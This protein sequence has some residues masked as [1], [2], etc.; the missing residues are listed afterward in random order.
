MEKITF[1]KPDDWHVHFRDGVYLSSTVPATAKDCAR[2]L[3]MPNLVPPILSLDDAQAYKKRILDSLPQGHSF[4]PLM[5]LYLTDHISTETLT[6]AKDSGV[7]YGCKLY[8]AGA[9]THSQQGI[10][11][12]EKLY[13]IFSHMEKL[14]LPLLIH[15][16]V[17]D[18][19]VDVFDREKRFI[20]D[21]L[22]AICQHFPE[23]PI[24]LEHITTKD[25]VHF[26]ENAS[27]TVAATITVHHLRHNRNALFQKG[28]NP[29][30]YCL[31]VLKRQEH[32]EALIKAATSGNKKFFL[33]TDSAPHTK[34]TKENACGCA[35]IF[36]APTALPL[37]AEIFE[38]ANALE[39]L[40]AFCSINGASFY[41]VPVN[42]GTITLTKQSWT[43]PE[44]FSF[45]PSVVI[46]LAAGETL[47]WQIIHE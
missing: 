8:P 9:T 38:E 10:K 47:S 37:L 2:A 15:G 31:P 20:E 40:E 27:D 19:K 44:S 21:H 30:Y 46:P 3:V 41:K 29:H 4:A 17:T 12:I 11:T 25:A 45:G 33:G 34:E 32:Q 28:L 14:Q 43:V 35:G 5:T 23:L 6:R 16:E 13:P 42:Q 1:I 18:P 22:R 7:V 36:S 26:I 39:K 24:V